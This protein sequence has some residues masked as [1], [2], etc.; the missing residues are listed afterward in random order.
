MHKRKEK[1]KK[2]LK[3]RIQKTKQRKTKRERT[4]YLKERVRIK[5]G[6]NFS[7]GGEDRKQQ[8]H[9]TPLQ[10]GAGYTTNLWNQK[11][12]KRLITTRQIAP[13]YPGTSEPDPSREDLEE[14]PICF[15]VFPFLFPFL[16]P[17][18]LTTK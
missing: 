5:M 14:C 11:E 2:L 4:V 3:K 7:K 12:I 13:L 1:K 10:S 16:S 8:Q 9:V 18:L 6:A 17:F 15:L